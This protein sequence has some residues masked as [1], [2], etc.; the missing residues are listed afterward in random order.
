MDK[1]YKVPKSITLDRVVDAWVN[2]KVALLKLE[3]TEDR[4]SDSSVINQILRTEME[5]EA[6]E[7]DTNHLQRFSKKKLLKQK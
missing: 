5:R 7:E 3:G 2:R 6:T 1:E 4:I